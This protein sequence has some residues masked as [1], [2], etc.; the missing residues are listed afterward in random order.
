MAT[1]AHKIGIEIDL[2]RNFEFESLLT[3]IDRAGIEVDCEWEH[4]E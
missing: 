3:D 1:H 2:Q 4:V